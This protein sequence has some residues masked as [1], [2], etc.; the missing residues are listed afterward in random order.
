MS[1]NCKIGFHSWNGC[2]CIH[3]GKTRDEQHDFS[4]NCEKCSKCG[5]IPDMDQHNWSDD[6]EKCSVCGKTRE[7]HHSWVNDCE[8]CSKCGKVQNGQH[9]MANGMCQICGKGTYLDEN[10]GKSYKVINIGNQ[11]LFAENFAKKPDK[12][13]S[14]AY[15]DTE[16]NADKYGYLY[17]WETAK[18]IAPKGW[19]L[20]TKAEWERLHLFLG[21]NDKKVYDQIKVGGSSGFEGVFSGLRSTHKAYNSLGASAQYWSD[22]AEDEKHIWFFKLGAYSSNAKLEK[23]DPGLGLSV[24]F[25]KDK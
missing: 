23:G 10:S 19:H 22:T 5:K 13:N 8:N 4:K 1:F 20:P 6:C 11:I 2:N 18:S 14:W 12:G 15:D 21:S 3:C 25:F 24:R 7:K 16:I 9:K 17:D